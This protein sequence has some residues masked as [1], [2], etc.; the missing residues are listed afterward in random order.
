MGFPNK[1][2]KNYWNGK[3]DLNISTKTIKLLDKN[4]GLTF[5]DLGLGNGCLDTIPKPKVT[6]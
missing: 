3:K 1:L 5:Y 4:T 6:K 2:T